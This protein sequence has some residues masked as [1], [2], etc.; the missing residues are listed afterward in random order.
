[1]DGLFA[2]ANLLAVCVGPSGVG[3]SGVAL[4]DQC[5]CGVPYG[6]WSRLHK[7]ICWLSVGC[8]CVC[9][10]MCHKGRISTPVDTSGWM[11]NGL[12]GEGMIHIANGLSPH[13]FGVSGLA[14]GG[15]RSSRTLSRCREL[16]HGVSVCSA[17]CAI[18]SLFHKT[19]LHRPLRNAHLVQRPPPPFSWRFFL[20]YLVLNCNGDGPLTDLAGLLLYIELSSMYMYYEL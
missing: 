2:E 4:R 1:M 7:P 15:G 6:V 9:V 3:P 17:D 5:E 8:V 16:L 11:Y 12:S 14:V 19:Y 10:C 13:V 18:L 20:R